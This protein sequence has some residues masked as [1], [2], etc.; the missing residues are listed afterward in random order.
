MSNKVNK[1]TDEKELNEK[2]LKV[3]IK[4]PNA[5]TPEEDKSLPASDIQLYRAFGLIEQHNLLYYKTLKRLNILST[6]D[7]T[8]SCG[9]IGYSAK[10]NKVY[11]LLNENAIRRANEKDVAGLCEHEIGHLLYEHIFSEVFFNNQ[12]ADKKLLN[13][14]YD[15]VI[16]ENAHF[17]RTRL[18][19]IKENPKSM[20]NKG[21]FLDDLR[22]KTPEIEKKDAAEI[23]SFEIYKLLLKQKQE[24]EKKNQG[25]KQDK[26]FSKN[27]KKGEEESQKGQGEDQ[28]NCGENGDEQGSDDQNPQDNQSGSSQEQGDDQ[29]DKGFDTHGVFDVELDENGDA[30]IKEH[31]E[32]GKTELEK[33]QQ[34]ADI[35]KAVKDALLNAIQDLKRENKLE[36]AVGQLGSNLQKLVKEMIKSKTDKTV[37]YDFVTSLQIGSKRTWLKFN[38]RFPMINRGKKKIKKPILV[39]GIDASGSM[40]CDE[41]RGMITYQINECLDM[42]EELYIVVGDTEQKW[43]IKINSKFEFDVETIEF[44]GY[45]GTDM[46]FVSEY[47]KKVDADGIVLHTDGDLFRPYD[48]QGISTIFFIYGDHGKEVSGFENY[49]VYPE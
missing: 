2:T 18:K 12:S 34:K 30:H 39:Q 5:L 9:G 32:N 38:K 25:K 6:P 21:C 13:Q 17:I 27:K 19:E 46:N 45:G 7:F 10:E 16:N 44:T 29:D 23:H 1:Q 24:Q 36:Q 11:M 3:V 26:L 14:S 22:K 31:S 35:Q 43:A 28:D 48:D 40:N 33:D 42:C 8:L 49:R 47:A 41:F 4:N 15:Y 20:L 37:I